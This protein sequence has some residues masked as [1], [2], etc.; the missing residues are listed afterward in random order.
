MKINLQKS[1]FTETEKVFLEYGAFKITAF[2]YTSGV[3][4][5][6]VANQKCSFVF[7]PFKGQQI[8]HF[9]VNSQELS[10]QTTVKEPQNTMCYLENYGGFLYHC[11]LIS[12]GAPDACHPQHGELPNALYDSAYIGCGEDKNGKFITLGGEHNHDTAFVRKYKFSPQIKLYEN[13]S[14]FK[15]NICIENLRAKPLEYMYL[16]HINFKPVN[17]AKL[18]YTADENIH[19]YKTQGSAEL[20][21]YFEQLEQNP[22]IMDNIGHKDEV[23]D[24]EICFGINY[25]PDKFGRAH[26]LQYTEQG[27]CYV[28]HPVAELPYAIRWIS[29]TANEDALGMVLPATAEHLGYEHARSSGQLKLLEGKQRLEFFIEAGYLEPKEA[30]EKLEYFKE[31]V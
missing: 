22:H 25:K 16:C 8:W 6:K 14:M 20:T 29:R 1:F 28:S 5:L 17:G 23:Y 31:S 11:G 10:M 12:F 21:R 26:T 19:I 24:P 9:T 15:I 13:E 7:T 3:E 30:K 2:R 18:L 4:A 27:A